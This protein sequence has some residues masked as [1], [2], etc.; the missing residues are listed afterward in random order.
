MKPQMTAGQMKTQTN[1]RHRARHVTAERPTFQCMCG[2]KS[3]QIDIFMLRANTEGFFK[4]VLCED[5]R[6]DVVVYVSSGK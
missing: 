4:D 3:Q 2:R 1:R 6:A 5:E